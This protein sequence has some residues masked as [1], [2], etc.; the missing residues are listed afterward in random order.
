MKEE[1]AQSPGGPKHRIQ[2]ITLE[3]AFA[4]ILGQTLW[5]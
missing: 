5:E 1:E 3:I 4:G 2:W